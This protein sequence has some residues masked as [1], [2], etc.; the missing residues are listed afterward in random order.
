MKKNTH[1][2]KKL[3]IKTNKPAIHKKTTTKEHIKPKTEPKPAGSSTT[4]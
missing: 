4:L 1:K 2:Q 3:T